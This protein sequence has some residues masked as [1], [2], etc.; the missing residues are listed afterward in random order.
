MFEIILHIIVMSLMFYFMKILI[1]RIPF[2]FA[3]IG[4]FEPYTSDEYF[5]SAVGAFTVFFYLQIYLT[6]KLT[7]IA[8][9]LFSKGIFWESLLL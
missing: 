3:F 5:G 7:Y 2:I 1:M 4:D 9:E 6:D 8:Q